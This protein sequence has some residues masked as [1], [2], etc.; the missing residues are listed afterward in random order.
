[1]NNTNY[2]SVY[3]LPI[4]QELT[5]FQPGE[6]I[7][8]GDGMGGKPRKFGTFV[9]YSPYPGYSYIEQDGLERVQ[10]F[11]PTRVLGRLTPAAKRS[12]M[13][14]SN[15]AGGT[16]RRRSNR[17]RRNRSRRNRSRRN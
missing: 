9:S 13:L 4:K 17:S 10:T 3:K 6:R 2:S 8:I 14:G 16:R 12:F 11:I 15:V 5:P 1:M 7:F